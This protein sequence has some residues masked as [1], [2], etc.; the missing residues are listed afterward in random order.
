MD[1]NALALIVAAVVGAIIKGIF[2]YRGTRR[3]EKS[4][5]TV[6]ADAPDKRGRILDR[7]HKRRTKRNL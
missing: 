4:Q 2:S 1:G 7:V 5:T 6:A 3:E